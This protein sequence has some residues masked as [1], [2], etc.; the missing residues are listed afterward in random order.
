VTLL[1]VARKELR[2]ISRD[3]RSLGVVLVLPAAMTLLFGTVLS[4]DVHRVPLAVLDGDGTAASRSLVA[5]MTSSEY[6]DLV[7]RASSEAELRSLLARGTA[8]VALVVRPGFERAL[9]GGGRPP[10]QLLVD[11]SNATS[12]QT[13]LGYA[14]RF[15]GATGARLAGETAAPSP[16]PRLRVLYNPELASDRF[17]L[18]GLMAMILMV[19][20]TVA[21][22]LSIVKERETGTME[23]LLVSPLSAAEVVLGKALPYGALSLL[24]AL[25]VMATA[26]LAF[27]LA[28]RGSLLLF[29]A[30]AA[31]FVLGAQGLGLVISSVTTS[32][33]VAF[34]LATYATMLPSFV[35]SG[36]V[37]PLRSMPEPLQWLSA[38]VP[39]RYFVSGLRSVVLKGAGLGVV[40]PQMAALAAFAA[41][42]LGVAVWRLH[43]GRL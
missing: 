41:S 15:L 24:A 38:L 28:V 14:E 11:G 34:Q 43:R 10:V 32:Q 21:T 40:W 42:M 31:L 23:Q 5:A 4:L 3:P 25:L 35:I 8:T 39:A 30:L 2:Q 1:A 29:L 7:A 20:A 18:P 16:R 37:F 26:W 12:A 6:F 33:Q 36:F 22:A 13:A 9:A 17:L 19:S 27:G